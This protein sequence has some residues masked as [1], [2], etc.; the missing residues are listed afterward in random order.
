MAVLMKCAP[1]YLIALYTLWVV[2]ILYE[3]SWLHFCSQIF[4]KATASCIC[5]A[6]T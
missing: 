3:W 2:N 6:D 4:T 1:I 5:S